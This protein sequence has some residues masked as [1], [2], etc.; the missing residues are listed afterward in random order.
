MA[1]GVRSILI[2]VALL[3]TSAPVDAEVVNAAAGGFAVRH[4]IAIKAPVD[5]VWRM[6]VS[7][8]GEWWHPDHT[9]S[10]SAANLYIE[11]RALGCFCERLGDEGA[12]V[13]MTV[14]FINPG[15][16]LRLTGGLGPLGL[17][18]VDGN[19]T[20]SLSSGD[21]LTYVKLDYMLG[22]YA[23]D[24]LDKIAPAVDQVLTEQVQRL[25]RLIENG[26]AAPVS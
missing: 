3:G 13:H 1:K 16:M 18:G 7:H 4:Q 20:F 6:L 24:G 15:K 2:L 21:G 22:G 5:T 26:N 11:P 19:M 12:V 10:G 23:P 25:R 8:V 17:M 14:T 9:Y